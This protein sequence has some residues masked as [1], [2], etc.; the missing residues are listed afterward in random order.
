MNKYILYLRIILLPMFSSSTLAFILPELNDSRGHDETFCSPHGRLSV[1]DG[2]IVVLL[3]EGG[4]S[5]FKQNSPSLAYK[6]RRI[7]CSNS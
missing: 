4:I 1:D 3:S 6:L 7:T 2:N 5:L